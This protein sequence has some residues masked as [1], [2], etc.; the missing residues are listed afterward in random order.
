MA[1]KAP[2]SSSKS[3]RQPTAS[4]SPSRAQDAEK[5]FA[6]VQ[7]LPA[8]RALRA[9]QGAD[10]PDTDILKASG[11]PVEATMLYDDLFTKLIAGRIDYFPRS[12]LEVWG[13]N[14]LVWSSPPVLA[15][16]ARC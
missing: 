11:L 9:G 1:G 8:L 2:S 13:V 16:R 4:V 10:W 14:A 15:P 5:A 3:G 12:L 6:G 7:S